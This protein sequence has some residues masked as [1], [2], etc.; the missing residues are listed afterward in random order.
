M[1]DVLRPLIQIQDE[2]LKLPDSRVASNLL[3]CDKCAVSNVIRPLLL[4]L[5]I[6]RCIDVAHNEVKEPV[7]KGNH[8][9]VIPSFRPEAMQNP[10]GNDLDSSLSLLLTHLQETKLELSP[11]TTIINHTYSVLHFDCAE[12]TLKVRSM[13]D[14]QVLV[15]LLVHLIDEKYILSQYKPDAMSK[16]SQLVLNI[17]SRIPIL[18]RSLFLNAKRIGSDMPD[19]KAGM[20][21]TFG[22]EMTTRSGIHGT[23][24]A[25][26]VWRVLDQ[27][28]IC[29][30]MNLLAH[31]L[32][33][34]IN[35]QL[36]S[37]KW[38]QAFLDPITIIELVSLKS[39][40][41]DAFHIVCRCLR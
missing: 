23:C 1:R 38:Q 41:T 3:A 20:Y 30:E 10:L 31:S 7:T 18:P 8:T 26:L 11:T 22:Y 24:E 9:G 21:G 35:N 6:H 19:V 34:P 37:D 28:Y 33:I 2:I 32:F 12:I 36:R 15:D 13:S 16:A 4:H 27:N 14:A 17:F 5:A 39:L 29:L 25:A 40:S